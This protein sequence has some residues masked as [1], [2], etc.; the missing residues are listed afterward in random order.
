MSFDSKK[1]FVL[2]DE[3]EY[4]SIRKSTPESEN[5]PVTPSCEFPMLLIRAETR[6]GVGVHHRDAI[7]WGDIVEVTPIW[8]SIP[9]I[10]LV[11]VISAFHTAMNSGPRAD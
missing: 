11:D 7:S 6:K 5:M 3:T 2:R 10:A 9:A 1:V 8:I 4:E